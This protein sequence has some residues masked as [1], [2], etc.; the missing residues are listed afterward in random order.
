MTPLEYAL[1]YAQHGLQVFPV[2]GMEAGQ[3]SCG[4]DNCK[5]AGK[6]PLTKSG[7]KDAS[8]DPEKIRQWWTQWPMANVAIGTGEAS[9]IFVIDIDVADGKNGAASLAKLE[10]E[11]GPIPRDAVVRTGSGGWHIY[12][13]LADLPIR[14]SASEIGEH[15]DV[16]GSGGYV[17]AP[18]SLHQSGNHYVWED[19]HV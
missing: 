10:A 14:N 4:R 5:S 1:Q 3:C 7:C 9:G 2:H 11:I 18:P 17:V 8:S 19:A 15:I 16:R 13:K 12:L 6:H